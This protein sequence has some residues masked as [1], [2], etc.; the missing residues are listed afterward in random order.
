MKISVN[1]F[2]KNL[3]LIIPL[4][5]IVIVG[6]FLISYGIT[7][8]SQSIKLII[9]GIIMTAGLWLGCMTIVMYLWKRFP[10]ESSPLNHL[11]IEIFLILSYTMAFS[12][13]LYFLEKKFWNIP[14]V[15]NLSM[16]IFVTILITYFITAVHES[17]FF[18]QQWKYNFSRSVRLEKDN[19]EAKYEALRAQINPHFLF[20][21]LNSLTNMVQE[22]KPVVDYIQNLS[23][24]LR[25]MMKSG[26]RELVLLSEE[27]DITMNYINLQ[28]MRFTGSLVIKVVVPQELLNHAVPP[29]VLQMLIENSLKHNIISREKPLSVEVIA[30]NDSIT[31]INNLQKKTGVVSTGQGLD[32]I[33]GRYG[34]FT[35]R[36]VEISETDGMFKVKIPLL[37]AEL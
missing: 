17:V 2:N 14:Q 5:G 21:S 25:Y 33:K 19:I 23:A 16:E 11:L 27:L 24:L 26:E 3:I 7:D 1:Y 9:H 34:Y 29:L 22:N 37:Q 31:V 36:K 35:T 20:N 12:Y 6:I 13:L 32:N 28:L 10:W 18:Y 4:V 15:E 8:L 30:D